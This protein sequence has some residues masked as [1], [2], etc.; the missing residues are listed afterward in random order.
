MSDT[1]NT[2][3]K[4]ALRRRDFLKKSATVAVAAP[5]ISLLLQQGIKPAHAE[6]YGTTTTTTPAAS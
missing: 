4:H 2:I 1:Q 5:A 6:G 3:Q